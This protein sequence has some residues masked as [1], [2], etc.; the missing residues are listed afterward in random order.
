MRNSTIWYFILLK[1]GTI[2]YLKNL[3]FRFSSEFKY[4]EFYFRLRY[5]ISSKIHFKLNITNLQI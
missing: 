4:N 5:K 1:K 2:F 3:N